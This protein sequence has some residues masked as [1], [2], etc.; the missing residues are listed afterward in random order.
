MLGERHLPLVEVS[1][2]LIVSGTKFSLTKIISNSN[3][4]NIRKKKNLALLYI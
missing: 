2:Y 4:M 1:K 3:N